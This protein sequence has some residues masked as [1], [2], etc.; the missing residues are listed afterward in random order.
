MALLDW[1]LV[2]FGAAVAV[3]GSWIQLH[4]E[5]VVPGRTGL[6]QIPD[7]Q[8]DPA[9]V[10]QIRLLGSCFLCMGTFFTLQ[11]AVDLMRLPWWTGTLSG[12]AAAIAAVAVIHARIRRQRQNRRSVQQSPLPRKVLELR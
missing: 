8:L 11:M 3:A 1:I 10:A 6:R 4:P 2:A 7:W 9:A 12:V 5:R